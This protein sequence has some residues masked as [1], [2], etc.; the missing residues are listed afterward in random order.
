MISSKDSNH[1]CNKVKWCET[2]RLAVSY[3][4]TWYCCRQLST[5]PPWT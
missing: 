1:N 3:T 4:L 5:T 2:V